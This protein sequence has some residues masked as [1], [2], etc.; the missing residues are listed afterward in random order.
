MDSL[1]E[2]LNTTKQL[3]WLHD[4]YW[5]ATMVRELGEKRANELNL[6][7][8]ERFFR[9]Y[10]LMLLRSKQIARP[11]DIRDLMEIFKL[12]WANCF[13]DDLYIHAPI[14]FEG[15]EAL[16]TGTTCHA[17]NSLSSAKM[18]GGYACGCQSIRTGVMKALKLKQLHSIEKSLIN[19]DGECV[20]RIAFE[21]VK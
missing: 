9:K 6:K 2:Q 4:S 17:Y 8:N 10:T 16:W 13:F 21:P 1:K 5:H 7:A 11:R 19:G 20:V 3:W 14:T 12:V 18:T 15:N